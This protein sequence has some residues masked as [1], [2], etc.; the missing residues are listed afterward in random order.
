[1][2]CM[3]HSEIHPSINEKFI[4]KHKCICINGKLENGF[5]YLY[6]TFQFNVINAS[7]T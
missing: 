7:T 5:M 1:M 2:M 3:G 6:S 4:E